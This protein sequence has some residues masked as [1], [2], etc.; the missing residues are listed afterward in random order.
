MLFKALN[1]T[2]LPSIAPSEEDSKTTKKV[3]GAIVV[4]DKA[5]DGKKHLVK[6]YKNEQGIKLFLC[7]FCPKEFKKVKI[8]HMQSVDFLLASNIYFFFDEL[9][10][11]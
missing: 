3:I 9:I 8:F 1:S 6:V 10:F 7:N 4:A 5:K 11:L 2:G